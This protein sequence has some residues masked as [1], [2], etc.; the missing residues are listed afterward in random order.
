MVTP[1]P[2]TRNSQKDQCHTSPMPPILQLFSKQIRFQGNCFHI[3]DHTYCL[4]EEFGMYSD[5]IDLEGVT[6][7]N[8]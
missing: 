1:P 8:H 3:F 5:C 7:Q 4:E 6:T 2:S